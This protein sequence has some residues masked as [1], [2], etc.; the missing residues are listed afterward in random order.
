M[1]RAIVLQD[2]APLETI[3]L[4]GG[5]INVMSDHRNGDEQSVTVQESTGSGFGPPPHSHPWSETFYVI[6]GAV[7]FMLNEDGYHCGAGAMVYIPENQVH[8]F[9]SCAEGVKMI[10]FTA[11]GSQALELFRSLS[12][13]LKQTSPDELDKVRTIFSQHGATLHI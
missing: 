4:L 6:S 8:A 12:T 9:Q 7:D 2:T 10:E 1:H 11:A 5:L 13:F 3:E